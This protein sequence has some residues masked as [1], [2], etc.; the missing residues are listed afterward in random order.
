MRYVNQKIIP[1]ASNVS[2]LSGIIE[3]SQMY[4]VSL[5]MVSTG[6]AAAGTLKL[7]ASND[8]PTSGAPYVQG[9]FVPTNWSDISGATVNSS[10]A[11]T[12]LIPTQNIC[13]SWLRAVYTSTATGSN[14]ITAI[15]DTGQRQITTVATVADSSGSLNNKYFL[16]SSLNAYPTQKNFYV[17]FNV[18]S[19]GTDP[20][21]AGKTGV[22]VAL[23]TNASAATVGAGIASALS[24]LTSDFLT[25][26]GTTTVTIPLA[27]AGPVTQATNGA[28]SPGFTILTPTPGVISNLYG[29]HFFVSDANSAHKYYILLAPDSVVITPSDVTGYTQKLAGFNSGATAAAVGDAVGGVT[30]TG[31]TISNT[32]ATVTIVSTTS[33]PFVPAFDSLVNPTGFTFANASFGTTV[34]TLKSINV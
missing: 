10:G 3:S 8:S 34:V 9:N 29:A 14:T 12:V 11:A 32:A 5:Q 33:G 15:A 23:S 21:L 19:A 27:V 26:T 18:N 16:I 17:W 25:C 7:Q 28:A 13:Y 22:Q 24:A 20:A 1:S 2:S 30:A 4:Q 31:L 6:S